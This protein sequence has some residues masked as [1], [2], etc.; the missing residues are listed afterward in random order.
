MKNKNPIKFYK[1]I[2]FILRG[3]ILLSAVF[4]IFS[5]NTLIVYATH[6]TPSNM[7]AWWPMWQDGVTARY[8]DE[9]GF[10]TGIDLHSDFVAN[11]TNVAG[12]PNNGIII[13]SVASGTPTHVRN[14]DVKIAPTLRISDSFRIEIWFK[15]AF[16]TQVNP[17]FTINDESSGNNATARGQ[18][19]FAIVQNG[20]NLQIFVRNSTDGTSGGQLIFNS[21]GVF[22]VSTAVVNHFSFTY[23]GPAATFSWEFAS[24]GL[25]SGSNLPIPGPVGPDLLDNWTDGYSIR[26]GNYVDTTPASGQLWYG[27][28]YNT[29]IYDD[30]STPDEVFTYKSTD[31]DGDSDVSVVYGGSDC[32]DNDFYINSTYIETCD[33]LDNNCSDPNHADGI[34]PAQIDEI[35]KDGGSDDLGNVCTAGFGSCALSGTYVCNALKTSTECNITNGKTPGTFCNDGLE[36][37]TSD[38]CSGGG[39][40]SCDGT[41]KAV[42]TECSDID[43]ND[44][45]YDTCNANKTCSNKAS[46]PPDCVDT[47]SCTDNSCFPTSA[48]T[49]TCSNPISATKCLIGGACYNSGETQLGNDCS[50]CNPSAPTV[51]TQSAN[52]TVCA[53]DGFGCTYNTCLSG[54]CQGG[55]NPPGYNDGLACTDDACVDVPPPD[56][57]NYTLT[58]TTQASKCLI[59]VV[60]TPTCF[61][62]GDDDPSNVCKECI[63]LTSNSSYSNKTAGSSCADALFCNGAETC[64][65]G[66]SAGVCLASS[67]PCPPPTGDGD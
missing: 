48:T 11:V 22:D 7:V 21:V 39:S 16:D 44:C 29:V 13:A 23:N 45:T 57:V 27:E 52:G 17:L 50:S 25:G 43:T 1:K 51:W 47:F 37:T 4:F 9:S 60:G 31:H 64:G 28:I 59:N 8:N 56:N 65:G 35:W 12:L 46:I 10:G 63:S 42:G 61:N 55:G 33:G 67:N 38:A 66:V 62:E 41:A 14:N 58:H 26:F 36:C 15:P 40:S 53:L 6:I 2:I 54:A 18:R 19:N 3:I 30:P 49:H 32:D 34:N 24:T 20:R 5:F